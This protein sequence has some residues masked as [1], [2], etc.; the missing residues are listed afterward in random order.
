MS[1]EPEGNRTT[2]AHR[3][4]P[5]TA[6]SSRARF[7]VASL[8]GRV[9]AAASRITRQDGAALR[10]QVI[11]RVDPAALSRV[12]QRQPWVLVVGQYGTT[13]LSS[14]L[15]A[16]VRA[17]HG[18]HERPLAQTEAD[19]GLDGVVAA[20]TDRVVPEL[21]VLAA[22]P[23][24]AVELLS[25]GDL[26]RA[27][28]LVN[29]SGVA[30]NERYAQA[31]RLRAAIDRIHAVV[32]V[33]ADADDPM[34]V[35]AAGS[36]RRTIW[37]RGTRT[38]HDQLLCPGCGSILTWNTD[39]HPG[40]SC[41]RRDYRQPEPDYLVQDG[42]ITDAEGQVWDPRLPLPGRLI[43]DQACFALATAG[44]LGINAGTVFVGMRQCDDALGRFAPIKLGE[45]M[46]RLI[47]ARHPAEFTD[48]LSMIENP[49][50][51]MAT[52]DTE[53]PWLWDCD[54]APL[55]S[56]T[57]IATGPRAPDVAVRLGH[58]GLDCRDVPELAAA[59]AGHHRGADVIATPG[60]FRA[61]LRLGGRS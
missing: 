13:V 36:A 6:A 38:Y 7:G 20:L 37:V 54:P 2:A 14:L 42:K 50:V 45:T 39:D 9:A 3:G 44:T 1:R 10:G 8:A 4:V 32:P 60:A 16:A 5:A 11:R 26:P 47:V 51:I 58:A 55:A 49:T 19:D 15:V 28:V 29:S 22:R 30:P 24:D 12:V 18:T 52:D 57:M 21:A 17:S 43:I 40:W 59:L 27:I 48:A 41:P 53:L 23:D 34:T 35:L 56:R 33:I 46:A 61:L 25:T 31:R